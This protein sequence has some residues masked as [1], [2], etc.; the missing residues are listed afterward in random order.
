MLNRDPGAGERDP[1]TDYA[2]SDQLIKW[3]EHY[4]LNAMLDSAGQE[5]TVRGC[6][7]FPAAII[8]EGKRRMLNASI[9]VRDLLAFTRFDSASDVATLDEVKT[10]YNRPLDRDHALE[11]CNYLLENIEQPF[12][13]S[14]SLNVIEPITVHYV[15]KV[16]GHDADV[17]FAVVVIPRTTRMVIVDGQHR[18]FGL[19]RAYDQLKENGDR[20]G[21]S[22][23]D[24][25]SV[26]VLITIERDINKSHLDFF[27]ASRTKSLPAS[28]LAV[29]DIRNV[30]RALLMDLV[31]NSSLFSGKRIDY[32]STKMS[33]KSAA[34]YL[35]NQV[36]M[37][38]KTFLTGGYGLAEEEFHTRARRMLTSI[39]DPKYSEMRDRIIDYFNALTEA[40]PLLREAAS[41]P[42]E[43][44]SS[45]FLQYREVGVLL[46]TATGLAILARV[47]YD[48]FRAG[49]ENWREVV[50]RLGSI[51]WRRSN[52]I[53]TE[54]GVVIGDRVS[55]AHKSITGGANTIED[56]IG[57]T[58]PH[59]ESGGQSEPE[60]D[61]DDA[62]DAATREIATSRSQDDLIPL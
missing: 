4:D 20:R 30:A 34:L 54:S 11:F 27:D 1:N 56:A 33:K 61:L 59:R 5:A 26:P 48:L 6:F 58:N 50:Q 10:K 32:T 43:R 22:I 9:P 21:E 13:P 52:P 41:L 25:T 62:T 45:R 57:W 51:D 31:Q 17:P 53:W 7:K 14:F 38:E 36:Y 28:Q 42:E 39:T 60:I 47:G 19:L 15:P 35:F 12:I 55:T 24:Q 16:V 29:Y 23:L 40:I 18:I 8:R 2:K 44:F 3:V 37:A 46:F 49:E